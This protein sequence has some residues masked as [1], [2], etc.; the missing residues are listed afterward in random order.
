MNENGFWRQILIVKQWGD[1]S[2][3]VSYACGVF[4]RM[5]ECDYNV[6]RMALTRMRAVIKQ[7]SIV[8]ATRSTIKNALLTFVFCRLCFSIVVKSPVRMEYMTV[9]VVQ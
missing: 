1:N 7:A 8:V 6:F 4:K 2:Y 9:S 3:P 5:T